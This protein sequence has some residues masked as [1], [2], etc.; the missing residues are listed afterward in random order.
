MKA[1]KKALGVIL[2]AILVFS[3]L[4]FSSLAL[5]EDQ[6]PTLDNVNVTVQVYND[7]TGRN[8]SSLALSSSIFKEKFSDT[9]TFGEISQQGAN[10]YCNATI[11]AY[12]YGGDQDSRV[13]NYLIRST[14]LK[15]Y[16]LADGEEPL[17]SFVLVYNE[18][19]GEWD[20]DGSSDNK[21]VFHISKKCEHP[22][23]YPHKN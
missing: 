7:D 4:P 16:T 22:Y 20:L 15:E 10:W 21:L 19:S 12:L 1:I 14:S 2:S 6:A 17:R 23:T 3:V 8:V 5:T 11:D 13:V 18:S 9:V